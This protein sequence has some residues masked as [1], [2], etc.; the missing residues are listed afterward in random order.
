MDLESGHSDLNPGSSYE[1]CP[2][3][4][5]LTS[6]CPNF[7][8][9]GWVLPNSLLWEVSNT[10]KMD[11]TSF[12]NMLIIIVSSCLISYIQPSYSKYRHWILLGE[13]ENYWGSGDNKAD[14]TVVENR[15]WCTRNL[16]YIV[17]PLK[18]RFPEEWFL[19]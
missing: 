14:K 11:L 9:V 3:L 4:G 19:R 7:F 17:I 1:L 15:S 2:C 10:V 6:L 18:K 16:F 13:R 12:Y 8:T 5:N